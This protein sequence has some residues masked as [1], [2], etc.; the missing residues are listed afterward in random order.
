[1]AKE[2][3]YCGSV[4]PFT[5]DHVWPSCFLDRFGRHAA[6]FSVRGQRVHGADYVVKDVC[7]TCNSARLSPLDSYFCQLYDEYFYY[8]HDFDSEVTFRYDFNLLA[9]SL[10]K[11]SYN[12][13]RQ[14]VSNPKPLMALR[15]FISGSDPR[16]T[17][18]A[19]FIELVSPTMAPQ[20]DG[21]ICKVMPNMYRSC[22]GKYLGTGGD[23]ILLR[24]VAINSYYFHLLVPLKK[25][26]QRDFD[27]VANQFCQKLKGSVR[28]HPDV[29]EVA[30]HTSPQD[31][32]RSMIPQ[33]RAYREQYVGSL[34][35]RSKSREGSPFSAAYLQIWAHR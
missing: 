24:L 32:I 25:L 8:L 20:S 4:G 7:E 14:G 31:G 29:N 6:H 34:R 2:C 18:L 5:D 26:L 1:M 21:S 30:V 35:K 27:E 22:L 23:S 16:P 10:L 17:Q 12:T 19:I 3:A 33:L 9:R 11:I 15:G 13:A 28:L